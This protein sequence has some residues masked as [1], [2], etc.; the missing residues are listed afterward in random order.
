MARR[1]MKNER[2]AAMS[3][4]YTY[5]NTKQLITFSIEMNDTK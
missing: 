2:T 4:K 5:L 1:L 3:D